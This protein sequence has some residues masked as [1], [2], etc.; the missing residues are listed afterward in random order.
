MSAKGHHHID[1]S[2]NAFDQTADFSKVAR[3]V[4]CAIHRAQNIDTG[5]R[6]LFAFFLRRH[7]ALGHS[8]F[9]EDPRH[10]P[11]GGFP[12]ILINGARQ[13]TLNIRSLRGHSATDHFGDGSGDDHRWKCGIKRAP[14]PFHRAFGAVATKLFLAQPCHDYRKLMR[15]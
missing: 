5:F 2:P 10:G 12:L 15:R 3:H 13:K 4:E 11:V 6:I 9:G 8:E 7:T 1:L 14:C